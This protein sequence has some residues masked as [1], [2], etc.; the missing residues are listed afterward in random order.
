MSGRAPWGALPNYLV[1]GVGVG[2]AA[3]VAQWVSLGLW[4]RIH[5]SPIIG[6]SGPMLLAL[7]LCTDYRYWP[8]Y[9]IGWLGG[10]MLMAMLMEFPGKGIF[11][12][13]L[14]MLGLITVAA[15]LLSRLRKDQPAD[16]FFQLLVFLAV[17]VVALPLATGCLVSWLSHA[18]ELPGWLSREWWHVALAGSLGYVLLTPAILSLVSSGSSTRR[19]AMPSWHVLLI[20]GAALVILW[21]GWRELGS[22]PMTRPLM[23]L[24]P[25]PLA[26]FAAMRAQAV[27]TCVVNLAVGLIAIQLSLDHV[28]PFVQE[29]SGLTTISVQL[30]M[31]GVAV[32]SLYLVA[33]VEQR[34]AT[35][36]ALV[37]SS[38]EVRELAGRLI[39]AQE[40]ERARIARDLHDDINQRLAV[41]SIRLS[42]LR[43][44][45]GDS[46]KQDV[47]Q[48]Q[49]EL[50]ALSEDVRHLSHDLHPSMLA[51]TGLTA[52]LAGLCQNLRHRSG[53]V[54]ELRVSPH[55]KEL[56][57]DVAL[58]LY[59][60]TQE[61]L[62]NALRHAQA[63]R[64]EVALQ[65]DD[66]RVNLTIADNG[67]GFV[68]E[69]EGRR[70][71]GLMS[72]DER[73]KLLGGSYRLQSTLGKGTELCIQIPLGIH[74]PV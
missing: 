66:H 36:R 5:D 50:I 56:P 37:V 42:A 26:I 40:Q 11:A 61:A 9:N 45:V 53:P 20:A 31:L 16:N 15:W 6:L 2:L 48:L 30:W 69:G 10:M 35:Q 46:N 64:I 55:A 59:R 28:G 8:A 1:R 68:T 51:Q 17:A 67:N 29:D 14:V 4:D 47:S 70:G 71:L 23:L 13:S 18:V 65:I 22:F 19:D 34:K 7:L 49:S 43:R 74:E 52:A 57:E 33:L 32:A 63:Q 62:G 38:T 41:A 25:V 27:G 12:V 58:C 54:I 3:L 73:T 72:I 39:V 24:A 60:V 44:K 21:F